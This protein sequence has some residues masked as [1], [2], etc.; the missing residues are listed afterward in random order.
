[1]KKFEKE[2][3]LDI[4]NIQMATFLLSYINKTINIMVFGMLIPLIGIF[5]FTVI[6]TVYLMTLSIFSVIIFRFV[7]LAWKSRRILTSYRM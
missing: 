7:L 5:T 6:Q 1:M 2:T 4:C 3:V